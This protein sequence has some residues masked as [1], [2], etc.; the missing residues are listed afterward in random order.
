VTINRAGEGACDQLHPQTDPEHRFTGFVKIADQLQ[1]VLKL[2]ITGVVER[3]HRAAHDDQPVVTGACP[4]QS[5]GL[6]RISRRNMRMTYLIITTAFD[7]PVP[8]NTRSS[9]K[10]INNN[11]NM[12]RLS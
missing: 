1:N 12:H 5:I 2:R 11:K 9:R 6:G 10:I 4:G 7:D 8:D 3:I